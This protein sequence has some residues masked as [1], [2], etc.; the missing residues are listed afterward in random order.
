K[1]NECLRFV[2]HNSPVDRYEVA[3]EFG[4]ETVGRL[5]SDRLLV[6]TG[7]KV[8]VYWDVFRDYLISEET[9]LISWGYMP[10]SMI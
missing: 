2:A 1:Q 4:E 8:S 9:P 5:L 6:R 7:E 3:R 10:A